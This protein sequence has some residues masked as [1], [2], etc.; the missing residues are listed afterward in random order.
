MGSP[1]VLVPG[2][3][4]RENVTQQVP[5]VALGPS[6]PLNNQGR[7]RR[8]PNCRN[9]K[10]RLLNQLLGDSENVSPCG[11]PWAHRHK[12]PASVAAARTRK[13]IGAAQASGRD[14]TE[15]GWGYRTHTHKQTHTL[16]LDFSNSLVNRPCVPELVAHLYEPQCPLCLSFSSVQKQ[17]IH[18]A[19]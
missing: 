6:S 8:S 10:R 14:K 4:G 9:E 18:Q 17:V 19:R 11:Q 15:G 3:R 13:N 2:D 7:D 16:A 5:T 12:T 1:E